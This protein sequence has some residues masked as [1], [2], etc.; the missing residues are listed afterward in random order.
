MLIDCQIVP[1]RLRVLCC[2]AVNVLMAGLLAFTSLPL[3]FRIVLILVFSLLNLGQ[4][5]LVY[6]QRVGV[7]LQHV[8]QVNRCDWFVQDVHNVQAQPAQ[9]LS[10]DFRMFAVALCFRCETHSYRLV[11]WKD[12]V[13]QAEWRK[14]RVLSRVQA[15]PA[16]TV[17]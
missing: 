1:S 3:A 16:Q 4:A 17:F 13:N 6:R 8:W 12:Q 7:R 14:L 11:L 2:L 9:L 5:Y 10:V 15:D